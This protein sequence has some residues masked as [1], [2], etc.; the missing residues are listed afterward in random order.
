VDG[1]AQLDDRF[2]FPRSVLRQN[3]LQNIVLRRIVL[4]SEYFPIAIV[5]MGCRFPGGANSP[6]QYWKLLSE[7]RDAIQDVPADRWNQEYFH[8]ADRTHAGTMVAPQG[9]FIDDVRGFDC[10][11]FGLSRAEA[12]NMDPQQRLLLQV[13][14]ESMEQG[15]IRADRW[16]GR[17]VGVFVGCFTMDYH[18]MQF[19]DPLAL[20]AY[21][22]TG[23]MNTMLSNRVSH[24]FDFRGPSMSIDTACSASLTAVHQACVSLQRG[25][26][27]MALAAGVMLM[28][29][30]DYH[31]AESKTGFL[32]K[33]GRCKS[34]SAGANGYVRS[35]G[36][37]T[38]VLKRITDALAAGDNI[39]GVIVGSAIN[40]G[41]HTPGIT[42][43]SSEAQLAVMRAACAAAGIRSDSVSYVEAHGTGTPVGD[44]AE[45][46]SIS[47]VFRLE[48]G[49][50][51]PLWIGSCKSNIG[52]TE[53]A[54][55][56]AGLIKTVLCLQNK[57]IP[58]NLH[59]DPPSPAIAFD[60]LRLRIPRRIEKLESKSGP[61]VAGVNS[62]GFGG[63][64]AHVLV[65]AFEPTATPR[66][67]RVQSCGT[68]VLLLSA[69][70]DAALRVLAGRH[71]EA[72][73]AV[74]DLANWCAGAANQRS[75]MRFRKA[76][77]GPNRTALKRQ[78]A[79]YCAEPTPASPR[80]PNRK[81]LVWVFPGVGQLRYGMN[82]Y[83]MQREPVFR[84]MYLRCEA[85]YKQISAISVMECLAA[86]DPE[87]AVVES[88]LSHPANLFYQVSVA[89]VWRS[90][91]LKPD[92]I[93][94]HSAGEYSAFYEAG[95]FDLQQSLEFIFRRVEILRA[96]EGRGAMLAVSAGAPQILSRIKALNGRVRIGA[97]NSPEHITLSGDREALSAVAAELQ[98]E[99]IN[100]VLLS[101]PIAY[102]H[103]D[104]LNL[105]DKRALYTDQHVPAAPGTPIY[106]TVTGELL[107]IDD[108][109]SDYWARNLLE[110]VQ[111]QSVIEKLA[112]KEAV[113]FL[114][115]SERAI[116][117]PH[118]HATVTPSD[119]TLVHAG[120][121]STE[122]ES[123]T[124]ALANLYE[125]GFDVAW[126]RLYPHGMNVNLPRYPWQQE[127]LWQEPE[128]STIRRM[129]PSAGLL[130][131]TRVSDQPPAWE[132]R[133]S[134]EKMPWLVEHVV[135]GE[136]VLPGAVCVDMA[137][138]ALSKVYPN[139]A[140]A[141][142]DV[143][144]KH[145]LRYSSESAFF[146]RVELMPEPQ[147]ICI[148]AS[149]ELRHS[150]FKVVVEASY[151]F[152]PAGKIAPVD[153]ELVRQ[154]LGEPLPG[155][156]IYQSF[157][158]KQFQYGPSFQ[159]IEAA[160][161]G[162]GEALCAL[163]L[164]ETLFHGTFPIR[165]VVLDCAFQVVLT[166][167][168]SFELPVSIE[169][170][171][172]FRSVVPHMYVHARLREK[173]DLGSKA[174]LFIYDSAGNSIAAVMGFCTRSLRNTG[175]SPGPAQLLA[176]VASI[177]AWEPVAEG[178]AATVHRTYLLLSDKK[179]VAAGL[180]DCL[181][182]NGQQVMLWQ[183]PSTTDSECRRVAFTQLLK[184]IDEDAVVVNCLAVDAETSYLP[185]CEPLVYLAR[186]LQKTGFKFRIWNLTM[187]AQQVA[188]NP[189]PLNLNQAALWG[190]ARVFGQQEFPDNWG[191][192]IDLS[193]LADCKAASRI[194][195][196]ADWREDQL[197]L[198]GGQCYALRLKP[199]PPLTQASGS[200]AFSPHGIYF[201]TGAFGALGRAVVQWM[202][203]ANV[204]HIAL[205][206][207][208]LV[209]A[210]NN[211]AVHPDYAWLDSLERKGV[212]VTVFQVDLRNAASI[213][214]A[215]AQLPLDRMRGVM[216]CAGVV[217]DELL[218]NLSF[219]SLQR[220]MEVK[221]HGATYLHTALRESPLEHFV[222]FSS[223]ASLLP[224]R[225]MGS[226]AAA[227]AVLDALAQQRWYEGLPVISLN[228]GP[229]SE[230]MVAQLGVESVF[231]RMGMK[232]FE[233]AQGVAALDAVFHTQFPQVALLRAD[234]PV[235][236]SH[237]RE[238]DPLLKHFQPN[239]AGAQLVN[240]VSPSDR[241]TV[242]QQ[243]KQKIVE[244]LDIAPESL[245]TSASLL[246]HGMES[247][248]AM[249]LSAVIVENW[250][251]RVAVNLLLSELPIDEVIGK[252]IYD[253]FCKQ[254]QASE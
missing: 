113:H 248:A 87:S 68:Y 166:L 185:G 195:L 102:H 49:S 14:W 35:E 83:L 217:E 182:K 30:P 163:L 107:K 135:M 207:S 167:T 100:T 241:D 238:S 29:V 96:S 54:A 114:E 121:G 183:P 15:G 8:S 46:H 242:E 25:E 228:W 116:L 158:K 180:A 237:R 131:G 232:S 42:V 138:S 249:M 7:G 40:H 89:A 67:E 65:Q 169:Q 191:G 118:I 193:S 134:T 84:E 2:L 24:A 176:Q 6:E 196:Q 146:V 205:T 181:R 93:V 52:H 106:S 240:P 214:S 124:M 141:L 190:M 218:A 41:G 4:T 80:W 97:Y 247:I 1:K 111:F 189:L 45:A 36:V 128:V 188:D 105:A 34:F 161:V 245:D 201:V 5:G 229:W 110:P 125:A 143:S 253:H 254:Q 173:S 19:L 155:P 51:Q 103:P 85:I 179:G 90:W 222:L 101:E 98:V 219:E 60:R 78:L 108:I 22:A 157:Q 95:I 16:S 123:M 177:P 149:S 221:S 27:D 211:W 151:R 9:G 156:E 13:S 133:F 28:L 75:H 74:T 55:G 33:D 11:F 81:K 210:R 175:P 139:S 12:A 44:P 172:V 10:Q 144:F 99:A 32:S 120:I 187:L 208:R 225:G 251:V 202:A 203:K 92:A 26:S 64:N 147:R 212:E 70:S 63:A 209:P 126:D 20:N 129:R 132:A 213:Q 3:T 37:G 174:D 91:G 154:R 72:L 43:P 152:L 119:T 236:L 200:P 239:L 153:I 53:A 171:R 164:D 216:Y 197:A 62:F 130:L 82:R 71:S 31:I 73:N 168:D 58:P 140:F 127:P 77:A 23:I 109:K 186:S 159:G 66:A 145:A 94:G 226:Y 117:L 244:L 50:D 17:A 57:Q 170:I 61:L 235:L 204:R 69:Q 148:R 220:V 230:G 47:Q 76:F 136:C 162:D 112:N 48:S 59:S 137:I 115:L 18:L 184:E 215:V 243:L 38:V 223:V 199:Y 246:Q 206:T 192:L 252:I 233:T 194:L 56:V 234:W 231:A 79:D 21:T 198:R 160:Q 227:N 150:D 86:K 122:E 39:Q 88:W 104:L 250:G 165:P 178:D 142:E 224:S